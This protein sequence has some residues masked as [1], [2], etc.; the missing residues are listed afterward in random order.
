MFK[1]RFEHTIDD[2]GRIS[3]PSKFREILTSQF[4]DTVVLT[5]DFEPC[6]VCY[7]LAVW[8]EFEKKIAEAPQFHEEIRRL[9]RFYV[10][11]AS[12]CQL[13]KQ[14]RIIVPPSL[15]EYASLN[16][17]VILVG[18][19]RTIE[20]WSKEKWEEVF[21]KSKKECDYKSLSDLGL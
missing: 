3:I 5:N 12:E 21:N 13:D 15:R 10:S 14:G 19:V 7:P 2:K 4:S 6:L 20:I 17:E 18:Q 8:Q 16:K 9:K 11:G 1:G